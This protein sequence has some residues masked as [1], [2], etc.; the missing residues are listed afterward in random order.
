MTYVELKKAGTMLHTYDKYGQGPYQNVY[1]GTV[2]YWLVGHEV[3]RHETNDNGLSYTGKES[4]TWKVGQ[5]KDG[6]VLK[7]E[8]EQRLE[9]GMTYDDAIVYSLD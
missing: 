5:T 7:T 2:E 9:T 8:I 6:N 3:Y 1:A 4:D